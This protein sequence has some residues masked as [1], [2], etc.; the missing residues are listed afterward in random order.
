LIIR[1]RFLPIDHHV[2]APAD[3]LQRDIESNAKKN[4]VVCF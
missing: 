4:L 3:D 2:R 1:R